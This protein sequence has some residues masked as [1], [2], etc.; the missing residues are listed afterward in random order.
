VF[1]SCIREIKTTMIL[2]QELQSW[3]GKIGVGIGLHFLGVGNT[4]FHSIIQL[5]ANSLASLEVTLTL[6]ILRQTDSGI[7]RVA[8]QLKRKRALYLSVTDSAKQ[9]IR[10]TKKFKLF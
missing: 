3:V 8:P 10:L 1:L 5:H 9:W 7:C 2:E 4:L 6:K